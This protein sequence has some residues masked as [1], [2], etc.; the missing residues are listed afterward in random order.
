MYIE[1]QLRSSFRLSHRSALCSDRLDHGF[2][3]EDHHHRALSRLESS[4][5]DFQS[6]DGPKSPEAVQFWPLYDFD[7]QIEA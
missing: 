3:Y 6:N 5:Q 4:S 7:F 1:I 2:I